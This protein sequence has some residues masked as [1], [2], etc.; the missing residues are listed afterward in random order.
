[1]HYFCFY[2]ALYFTG[3]GVRRD[4][5][6]YYWITGR[7]DDVINPS[8]H[9]LGNVVALMRFVLSLYLRN[10]FPLKNSL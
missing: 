4:A 6:G 7:V 1:M 3:D 9:R 2:V 5:D 8:G 10:F